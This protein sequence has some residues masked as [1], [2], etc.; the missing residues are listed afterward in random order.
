[1]RS[2]IVSTIIITARP[3][4]YTFTD[5]EYYSEYTFTD[6]E[7]HSEYYQYTFTDE[8]YRSE[9][10]HELQSCELSC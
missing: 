4:H 7:Y 1:M 6:E 5:E 3:N 10:W 2:T 9:S 8:E